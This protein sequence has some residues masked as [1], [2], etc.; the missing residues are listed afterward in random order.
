[1]YTGVVETLLARS[2]SGD[3]DRLSEQSRVEGIDA[4]S[5]LNVLLKKYLPIQAGI[6]YD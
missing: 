4:G 2:Q 5:A 6:R 1:V 3:H